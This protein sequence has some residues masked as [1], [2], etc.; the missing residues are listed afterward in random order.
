MQCNLVHQMQRLHNLGHQ[1]TKSL[2]QLVRLSRDDALF[3]LQFQIS[4]QNYVYQSNDNVGETQNPY[5]NKFKFVMLHSFLCPGQFPNQSANRCATEVVKT[6]EVSES[7]NHTTF[8]RNKNLL[9]IEA[10]SNQNTFQTSNPFRCY[11]PINHP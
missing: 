7:Y 3:F 11:G 9:H 8:I 2:S 6:L 1:Q 4:I 5:H 10:L